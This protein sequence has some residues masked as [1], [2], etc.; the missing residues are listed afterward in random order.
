M[1]VGAS[2]TYNFNHEAH[3]TG[4]AGEQSMH[5]KNDVSAYVKVGYAMPRIL[6]YVRSGY[7]ATPFTY[8]YNNKTETS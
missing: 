3:V 7:I 6:F 5:K 8:S 4:T 1:G 2:W